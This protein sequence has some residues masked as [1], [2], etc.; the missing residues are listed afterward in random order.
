MAVGCQIKKTNYRIILQ[1]DLKIYIK[2]L[3]ARGPGTSRPKR[4]KAQE[5]YQAAQGRLSLTAHTRRAATLHEKRRR[6]PV[7]A[8]I[9][10]NTPS[11]LPIRR[12]PSSAARRHRS[13]LPVR[14]AARPA[15]GPSRWSG[16]RAK[17]LVL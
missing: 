15:A 3:H 13:P 12:R 14:R 8:P 5:R 7:T 11:P 2:K 16:W 6:R 9:A 17:A 4:S 10:R 1:N